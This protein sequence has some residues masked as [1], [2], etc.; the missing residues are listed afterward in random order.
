MPWRPAQALGA[1]TLIHQERTVVGK[2]FAVGVGDL[3]ETFLEAAPVP[4]AR[5]RP[6]YELVF[7]ESLVTALR[8]CRPKA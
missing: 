3:L 4:I 7:S 1:A 6:C 5:P 8:S 2:N